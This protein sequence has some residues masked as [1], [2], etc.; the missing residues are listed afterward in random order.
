MQAVLFRH[1]ILLFSATTQRLRIC[2]MDM[3]HVFRRECVATS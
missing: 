3:A 2:R 1:I